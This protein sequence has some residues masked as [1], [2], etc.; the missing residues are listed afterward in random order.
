MRREECACR[1]SRCEH[2]LWLAL[3]WVYVATV[4]MLWVANSMIG[5]EAGPP[6][7]WLPNLS[8]MAFSAPWRFPGVL[9]CVVR[10]GP[11]GLRRL[12]HLGELEQKHLGFSG[13]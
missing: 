7:P 1:G 4:S 5:A 3:V 11:R 10:P 13:L 9:L 12:R 8:F 2:R 6:A